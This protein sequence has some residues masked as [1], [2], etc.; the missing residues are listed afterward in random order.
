MFLISLYGENIITGKMSIAAADSSDINI[1]ARFVKSKYDLAL[2]ERTSNTR[3]YK[4]GIHY[5]YKTTDDKVFV[6]VD[7]IDKIE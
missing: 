1:I 4:N 5:E 3:Y 2:E 6:H 7:T